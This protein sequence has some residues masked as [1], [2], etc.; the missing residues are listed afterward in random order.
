MIY[1]L[2]LMFLAKQQPPVTADMILYNGKIITVDKSFNIYTAVAIK[3]DKILAT[4]SD[5][6]IK[7]LA[8][9]NTKL[10]DLKGKTVI[11]GLTDAHA[12][13]ESASVSEL[14][15]SIPDVH[16]INDLL[17]WIQNQAH[18]KKQ[19]E[20]IIHPKLFFTRL[21]ELRQPTLAE[22]DSVAPYHPVFLNGSYGGMVNSA[23]LRIS[24][25][26]EQT[27]DPG[28]FRDQNTG[29]ITGVIRS[30]AFKLL[31]IPPPK[32]L[33][34]DE[35]QHALITILKKYNEMGITS[36]CS[37]G[38][39]YTNFENYQKLQKSNLLTVRIFQNIIVLPGKPADSMLNTINSFP[40]KTGYGD[41]MVRIGALKIVLDGGILTGTAY[42]REPWGDKAMKIFGISDT[43]FKGLIN[44]SH[45]D[46]FKIVKAAN[47]HDWKFTAHCTGGGGVDLLLDVFDEVNRIKSIKPRRFS[48]IHGNFFTKQAIKKMKQLGVYADMQPAWFYKD[49]DAMQFILGDKTINTFHPY[50]SLID[51]GVTVNGGSDHM[52][53]LDPDESINPY[54]PYLA[55]WSIVTRTT[56]RGSK[57][58]SSEAISRK[59]ALR[60]YTIN[61]AAASFEEKIK[62]SI[63]PG[64]LADLAVISDD[65]LNCPAENIKNIRA[66]LTILGGH[67]V[68]SSGNVAEK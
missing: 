24:G 65:I 20:W 62:G 39:T 14:N 26:T 67:I 47:D 31:K 46:L 27:Q 30:S 29:Q 55:M 11:P 63:E 16:S 51:A 66:D 50:R 35:K 38:G 22:L 18:E 57:I 64:K 59:E 15:Q 37:G 61:N 6:N 32:L 9:K 48:I 4:G 33:S 56:E 23:A 41:S 21:K 58:I 19:N 42:M 68:Y 5:R 60:M 25:I 17:S 43:S 8:G 3:N 44:Y 2:L 12:H 54:N 1:V 49:A 52:V 40:Y 45:E 36:I 10:I 7:K 53:K 28:I 13:P 34:P